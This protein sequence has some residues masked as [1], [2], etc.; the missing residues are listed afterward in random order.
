MNHMKDIAELFADGAA[1]IMP[2]TKGF[3][4]VWEDTKKY[5]KYYIGP[6]MAKEELAMHYGVD[7]GN[8]FVA[9]GI[10]LSYL[11]IL[12]VLGYKSVLCFYPSYP[13][14]EYYAKIAKYQIIRCILDESGKYPALLPDEVVHSHPD[15]IL[16]VNPT[17]P[18][19]QTIEK[20]IFKYYL[21]TFPQSLFVIDEAYIDY[22]REDSLMEECENH[23]N[24][25]VL[26]SLSKGYCLPAARFGYAF[27]KDKILIEKLQ[28]AVHFFMSSYAFATVKHVF[29]DKDYLTR[30]VERNLLVKDHILR[31]LDCF[32]YLKAK[33]TKTN[34][35]LVECRN[36]MIG[37]LRRFCEDNR[38][39]FWWFNE[40]EMFKDYFGYPESLH[41]SLRNTFRI[42]T[43]ERESMDELF[44]RLADF[45]CGVL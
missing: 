40:N 21:E 24:I 23:P 41:P 8:F 10:D 3:E 27:S 7:P 15:I 43:I 13:Y 33:E 20:S 44:N 36:V 18:G 31:Q 45:K 22:C 37:R 6:R 29:S 14:G 1:T 2:E 38:I 32:P 28:T 9:Y 19:G 5:T 17:N 34:F 39:T 12:Q 16:I 26:R 30:A 11:H 25:L 42:S 35:V 4:S